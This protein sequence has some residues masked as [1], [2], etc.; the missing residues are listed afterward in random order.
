MRCRSQ[1]IVSSGGRPSIVKPISHPGLSFDS[2]QSG[3]NHE[4]ATM[5][6]QRMVC[7][8][9]IGIFAASWALQLA[10]IYSV[11]G[12]VDNNAIA[13]WLVAA[14]MTPALGVLILMAFSNRRARMCCGRLIGVRLRLRPM[15][16]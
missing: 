9:C 10:G 12:N 11:H 8:Y 16:W 13:P 3:I 4:E 1:Q 2:G 14:M 7:V 5:T 6:E 15:P